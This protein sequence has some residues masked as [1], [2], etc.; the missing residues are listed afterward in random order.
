MFLIV[1]NN[2]HSLIIDIISNDFSNLKNKNS[3]INIKE[4]PNEKKINN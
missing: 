2:M 1:K 3:T 4:V